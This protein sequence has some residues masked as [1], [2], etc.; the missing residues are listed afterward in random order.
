MS[1]PPYQFNLWHEPWIRVTRLDGSG[2][3]LGIGTCLAEASTLAALSDPSPLVVGG[4]HRLLTAILQAINAPQ[5]LGTI[6]DLLTSGQFDQMRLQAFAAMHGERFDLFHPETPFLQTGDVPLDA[7]SRPKKDRQPDWSDPKP[8]SVLFVEVPSETNRTHFHHVTD[9]THQCCPS[10]CA[11]GLITIP[12]FASSG[13]A[14]IRPSINGVPPIYVLPSG[15]NLYESLVY[16]LVTPDFQPTIADP[17]RSDIAAWHREASV[18]REAQMSSAGYLESLTF[19]AHRVRLYPRA[20]PSHCTHCGA[21]TQ[22]VVGEVLFTMGHWLG[23]GS[24]IWDDPFVAFRR[25]RGKGKSTDSGPKA[26]RPEEGK[27]LWREYSGLLL[28]RGEEVQLRPKVVRQLARLV[29]NYG[30]GTTAPLLRFRCVG[31]RTD[32]KAKIFEWLDEALEVPPAILNDDDAAQYVDDA[33]RFADDVRFILESCFDHHF[34]P[35]RDRGG[36]NAKLVRFKTVRARMTADYWAHLA[37]LFR[38]LIADLANV[39][40]REAVA[41]DWV[42]SL[43]R[44]GNQRF[45]LAAH[46]VGM[47]AEALRARV[48]AQAECRRRLY[49]KQKE[50]TAEGVNQ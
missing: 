32:G 30:V 40:G 18:R 13:G 12:S 16:S 46:Q 15:T 37:P 22:I 27:A 35:E 43:V 28:A 41:R 11:R 2:A 38:R 5:S 4:T 8:V 10:C 48:E 31:M 47:S 6:A 3:N 42:A 21:A 20:Q 49:A 44:E 24:G 19:P 39:D 23:E 34:R 36:R 14:R 7:W 29:E 9:D 17:V 26:V 25:P 1:V 45:E 33:L 50:Q